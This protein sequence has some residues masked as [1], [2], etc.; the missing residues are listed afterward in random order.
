MLNQKIQYLNFHTHQTEETPEQRR[1]FNVLIPQSEEE[2]ETFPEELPTGRF[3]VGLHPKFINE[4]KL[5]EQIE[6]VRLIG[7]LEEVALIGECGLDRTVSTP[8]QV[9]EQAFIQQIRIAE[10]FQKPVVVHCVR[11]FNELISIK[12]LVKPKVPIVV[13]G[14]NNKVEIAEMLVERGFYL[15]FGAAL[16][17]EDSNASKVISAVPIDRIF[18]ENDDKDLAISEVYS[19]AARRLQMPIDQLAEQLI[20]NWLELTI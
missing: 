13:H 11:C 2:L 9:Q 17:H 15:S 7:K 6:L 3:S 8:L 16:Q 19:L 5:K 4:G 1:I 18:L 10:S 14:F 20:T 12:K